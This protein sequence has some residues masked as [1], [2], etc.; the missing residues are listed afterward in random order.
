VRTRLTHR[1]EETTMAGDEGSRHHLYEQAKVAWGV[2]A[3][4][5]LMTALPRDP[6]R[7]ATKDDLAVLG[8][9]LRS[10]IGGLRVE[11][12]SEIS[13]MTRTIMLGMVASNISLVALVFAAIR[14]A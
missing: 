12:H 6:D 7:F 9:E 2:D 1:N 11:L 8:A 10:E 13:G 5:T 14:L 4:A 3:A